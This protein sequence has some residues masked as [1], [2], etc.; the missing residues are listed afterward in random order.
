VSKVISDFQN[1]QYDL[2]KTDWVEEGTDMT[3]TDYVP[4]EWLMNMLRG[5]I[6]RTVE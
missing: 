3:L 2:S 4:D 6:N 1:Y 5:N